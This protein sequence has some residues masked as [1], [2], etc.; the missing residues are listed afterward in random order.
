MRRDAEDGVEAAAA[1]ES[2]AD[3]EPVAAVGPAKAVQRGDDLEDDFAIET[4]DVSEALTNADRRR[5]LKKKKKG[6]LFKN[7]PV[8][9]EAGEAVAAPAP[10]EEKKPRK[11]KVVKF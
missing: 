3:D 11:P 5:L 1:S 7:G 9:D 10:V 8:S 6:G 4:E 2:E